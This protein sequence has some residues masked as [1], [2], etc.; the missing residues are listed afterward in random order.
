MTKYVNVL[1]KK[2][3]GAMKSD[4]KFAQ[5]LLDPTIKN[6]LKVDGLSGAGKKLGFNELTT[7][8]LFALAEN[9]R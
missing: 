6:T 5:F 7:N 8:L 9:N 2:L 4:A 3:Q 1:Q